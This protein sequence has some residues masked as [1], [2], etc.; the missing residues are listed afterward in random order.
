MTDLINF[1]ADSLYQGIIG[2]WW[3]LYALPWPPG[4]D[5]FRW[6]LFLILGKLVWFVISRIFNSRRGSDTNSA[7]AIVSSLF[8]RH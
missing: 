1:L 6:L 3:H 2:L 8:D 5:W 4:R 7:A